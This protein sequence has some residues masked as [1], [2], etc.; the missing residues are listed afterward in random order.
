MA[1]PVMLIQT[2]PGL[3]WTT[4]DLD[5][6]A[7]H[8]MKLKVSYSHP[9]E[10]SFKC[11]V[12]HH[13]YPLQV[14]AAIMFYDTDAGYSFNTPIFEGYI[15][16]VNPGDDGHHV[17]IICYDPTR[18][19]SDEIPIMS[20]PWEEGNFAS[21]TYPPEGAGSVPRLV[22]NATID[23]D[24]DYAFS[25]GF[26]MSVGQQLALLFDDAYWPLHWWNAANNDGYSYVPGQLATMTFQPQEKVVFESEHLR[27]G[28]D[29]LLGTYPQV[30][31]L[32]YPG[33]RKWRFGNLVTDTTSSTLTLNDFTPSTPNVLTLQMQRTF[34]GRYTAVKVYGPE[35]TLTETHATGDMR[36]YDGGPESL[37]NGYTGWDAGNYQLEPLRRSRVKLEDYSDASGQHSVWAYREW[38]IVDPTKRKGAL[39]LNIQ[40]LAGMGDYNF[41]PTFAPTL[42]CSF[43]GGF[44]WMAV[45]GINVDNTNGI[46]ST[47]NYMYFWSSHSPPGSTQNYFVPTNWRFTYAHYIE[48]LWVRWPGSGFQGSAYDVGNIMTERK[49]YDE[50]LA[51]GYEWGVPVTTASR[52][53]Q[54]LQLCAT[55][56][57]QS[58]DVVYTGG[59][60][61][62]G[63]EYDYLRLGKKVNFAATDADGNALTT[64]WENVNALLT[65]VEYDWSNDTTS[66]SFSSN[67]MELIGWDVETLKSHLKIRA[68]T[69][70][71]F[72]NF[73]LVNL[74][75]TQSHVFGD[76]IPGDQ[77]LIV[78][79]DILYWDPVSGGM[80]GAL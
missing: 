64:G 51:V 9:A 22:M 27:G 38:Q 52:V 10:F 42:E 71:F 78:N 68:L 45:G 6:V 16:E 69:P 24:D 50:M 80:E 21:G 33:E 76:K 12:A 39:R 56:H 13:T 58:N 17:E 72:W 48:P 61:L 79:S 14:K 25:R 77:V 60:V 41:V 37:C 70:L 34:E 73:Y 30:R 67:W 1:A 59:A 19:A 23:N 15:D 11:Q 7:V 40:Y 65:D 57:D 49:I 54:F 47:A 66:L 2:N 53:A 5:A 63:I 29:R 35:A 75:Y 28:I 18:K 36:C 31:F 55:L 62:E 20:L 3:G 74:N 46:C 44:T 32:F 43:D 26:N 4:V 8:D